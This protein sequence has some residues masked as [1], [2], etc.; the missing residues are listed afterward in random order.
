V[1]GSLLY[2]PPR[3]VLSVPALPLP[4]AISKDAEPF[5]LPH[6]NTVRRLP[7][8]NPHPTLVSA[9]VDGLSLERGCSGALF[10]DA[11]AVAGGRVGCS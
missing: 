1:I 9:G 5:V 7:A 11:V 4:R 10:D 2:K 6:Q 3:A 8:E